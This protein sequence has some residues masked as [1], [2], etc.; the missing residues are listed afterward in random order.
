MPLPCMC[1]VAICILG[2]FLIV[3]QMINHDQMFSRKS[4][5]PSRGFPGAEAEIM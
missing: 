3:K 2:E 1:L 4:Y 5:D